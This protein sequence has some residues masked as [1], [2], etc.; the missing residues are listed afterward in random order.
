MFSSSRYFGGSKKKIQTTT[1]EKGRRTSTFDKKQ[2]KKKKIR[3]HI[4][5][6]H[7]HTPFSRD[8][9]R[10]LFL[11][12]LSSVCQKIS[13]T[14]WT[15]SRQTLGTKRRHEGEEEEDRGIVVGRRRRRRGKLLLRRRRTGWIKNDTRSSVCRWRAPDVPTRRPRRHAVECRGWRRYCVSRLSRVLQLSHSRETDDF[16]SMRRAKGF[17]LA[18][19][20]QHQVEIESLRIFLFRSRARARS[21][22]ELIK[23]TSLHKP[24]NPKCSICFP[25]LTISGPNFRPV[26][27]RRHGKT[28]WRLIF[29]ILGVARETDFL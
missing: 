26:A 20:P 24:T 2:K 17:P 27:R 6:T 25:Y 1:N 28:R 13:T 16:T 14:P 15:T 21:V 18:V 4:N 7:K 9:L 3:R 11:A 12:M 10:I 29:D 23:V 19:V 22:S 8:L 5:T